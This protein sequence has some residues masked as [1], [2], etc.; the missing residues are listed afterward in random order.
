MKK[1]KNKIPALIPN[2]PYNKYFL[3]F[4]NG[5]HNSIEERKQRENQRKLALKNQ[6]L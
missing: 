2:R 3:S 6:R 4:D 5:I 1:H